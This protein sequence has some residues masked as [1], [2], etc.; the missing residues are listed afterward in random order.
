MFRIV[1]LS[2]LSS[3]WLSDKLQCPLCLMSDCFI[4]FQNIS[5]AFLIYFL[6]NFI[7]SDEFSSLSDVWIYCIF[8][9][10][11]AVP[12]V[13]YIWL[14]HIVSDKSQCSLCLMSWF[15]C[16]RRVAVP[17]LSYIWFYH[18]VSDKLQYHLCLMSDIMFYIISEY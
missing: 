9:R 6:I 15:Y 3:V 8:F 13:P 10:P 14:Y 18:I 17:S 7:V 11:V 16:F 12:S 4:L 1:R 2:S 5:S